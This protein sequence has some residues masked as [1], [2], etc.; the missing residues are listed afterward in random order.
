MHV[1]ISTINNIVKIGILWLFLLPMI[2]EKR[3]AALGHGGSGG[4]SS[5]GHGAGTR[6]ASIGPGSPV[7]L[8]VVSGGDGYEDFGATPGTSNANEQAGRDD[9]T[10]HLLLW[11]VWK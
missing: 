3:R 6:R 1:A 10:N 9:S 2:T 7:K 4:K 11:S 8:L 5:H